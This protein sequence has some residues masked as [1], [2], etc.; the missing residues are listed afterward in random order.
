MLGSKAV[1]TVEGAGARVSN[2]SN[3][4]RVGSLPGSLLIQPLIARASLT[5]SDALWLFLH[6]VTFFLLWPPFLPYLVI[7]ER[8]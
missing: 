2:V 5:F 6:P 3:T 7:P 8:G 4:L 1:S